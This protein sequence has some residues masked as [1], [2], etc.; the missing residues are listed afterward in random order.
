MGNGR[1][2]SLINIITCFVVFLIVSISCSTVKKQEF[3]KNDYDAIQSAK[4]ELEKSL[5]KEIEQKNIEVQRYRDALTIN[6]ADRL[7]FKSGD[8]TIKKEGYAILDRIGGILKSLPNKIF[9]IEGHTD[10][11]PIGKNLLIK[12]PNNW[13]LGAHRATNVAEYLRMKCDIESTNL[14]VVTYSSYR[15]ILPNTSEENRAKNRRIEIV[16]M[17]RLDYQ[18]QEL[19]KSETK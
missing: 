14:V 9:R 10:D 3:T 2:L 4:N 15:P 19:E 11:V 7:F 6:I 18:V 13:M 16:V 5:R 1:S 8:A 17:N 12:Y